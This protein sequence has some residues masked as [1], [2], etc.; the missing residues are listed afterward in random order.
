MRITTHK[1][2]DKDGMNTLKILREALKG[3]CAE[4]PKVSH[5]FAS[6]AAEVN[7]R[8]E[9]LVNRHL[10]PAAGHQVS[11]AEAALNLPRAGESYASANLR[12]ASHSANEGGRLSAWRAFLALTS[13]LTSSSF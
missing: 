8:A 10:V 7:S 9:E 4:P 6:T 1:S 12:D 5:T 11:M 2:A 3:V 13:S